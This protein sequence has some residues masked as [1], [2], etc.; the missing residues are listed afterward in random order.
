MLRHV[1]DGSRASRVKRLDWLNGEHRDTFLNRVLRAQLDARAEEYGT[2]D[3]WQWASDMPTQHYTRLNARFYDCEVARA[4]GPTQGCDDR[5]PGNVRSLDYANRGT[6]NHLVQ[7]TPTGNAIPTTFSPFVELRKGYS[8]RAQSIISPGQS[9]FIDAAGRPSAHYEDQHELY[10]S[11]RY[12]PMPLRRHDVR[13]LGDS[14]VT[15]LTYEP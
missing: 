15:V 1:L 4:V 5:L 13:A 10:A 12:K 3:M 2:E 14:V 6:Y 11:W 7:F 9:G 8:V